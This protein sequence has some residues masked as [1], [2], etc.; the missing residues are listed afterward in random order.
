[1]NHIL[2]I[3][4]TSVFFTTSAVFNTFFAPLTSG[5][6]NGRRLC[7]SRATPAIRSSSISNYVIDIKQLSTDPRHAVSVC[8]NLM[9]RATTVEPPGEEKQGERRERGGLGKRVYASKSSQYLCNRIVSPY[10]ESLLGKQGEKNPSRREK[11]RGSERG[12][13]G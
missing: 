8:V 1:M 10:E 6:F 13:G 9:R 7:H 11:A 3:D 12:R 4:R 5:R 2:I